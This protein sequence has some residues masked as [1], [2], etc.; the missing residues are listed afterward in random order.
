MAKKKKKKSEIKEVNDEGASL[1]LG[2]R[3]Q[4]LQFSRGHCDLAKRLNGVR[5]LL[6]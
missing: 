2:P 1:V 5:P 3:H 4:D 6:F